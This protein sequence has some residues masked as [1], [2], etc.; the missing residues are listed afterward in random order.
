MTEYI[1]KEAATVQMARFKGYLDEDMILRL[2][3]ALKR[4]PAADVKPVVR[5]EWKDVMHGFPPEPTVVCSECGYDIVF[6]TYELVKG[7]SSFML[8]LYKPNF[9]PNCGADMRRE[10]RK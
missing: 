8:E 9:C 3:I 1:E 10:E 2:Q 5:G 4:L 7:A 6:A